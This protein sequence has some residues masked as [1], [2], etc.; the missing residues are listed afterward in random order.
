MKREENGEGP[1]SKKRRLNKWMKES[2][3]FHHLEDEE[4]EEEEEQ[5]EEE[6]EVVV[7]D[8]AEMEMDGESDVPSEVIALFE[9][10]LKSS[11]SAK[12]AE[13]AWNELLRTKALKWRHKISKFDKIFVDGIQ[14]EVDGVHRLNLSALKRALRM[15]LF[16]SKKQ[17]R[18]AFNKN[19]CYGS[20]EPSFAFCR[21]SAHKKYQRFTPNTFKPTSFWGQ[22]LEHLHQKTKSDQLQ[23]WLDF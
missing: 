12:E 17:H 6:E 8:D 5:K 4:G 19:M 14:I 10:A 23:K 22:K 1:P 18:I 13:I 21:E 3:L 7:V 2:D 20:K 9:S 15:K 16:S 11:K